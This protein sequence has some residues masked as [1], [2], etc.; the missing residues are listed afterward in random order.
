MLINSETKLQAL[1]KTVNTLSQ[2]DQ[3]DPGTARPPPMLALESDPLSSFTYNTHQK[4]TKVRYVKPCATTKA[5]KQKNRL[6]V[7][8]KTAFQRAT[9][10]STKEE[11]N[12]A[13][14]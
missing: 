12:K 5:V 11:P 9:R 8:G 14:S 13:Q 1:R 10:V 6:V 3:S 7:K 2:H 4:V